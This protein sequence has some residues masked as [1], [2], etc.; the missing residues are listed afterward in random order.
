MLSTFI[1]GCLKLKMRFCGTPLPKSIVYGD[2]VL[3]K[4]RQSLSFSFL[5]NV[6]EFKL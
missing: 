4:Q 5:P 3:D 6:R 2:V 1:F